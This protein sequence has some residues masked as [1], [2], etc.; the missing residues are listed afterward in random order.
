MDRHGV[1]QSS[2]PCRVL[3]VVG[4]AITGGTEAYV[5]N[6]LDHYPPD[7][8]PTVLAPFASA[9]TERWLAAGIPVHFGSVDDAALLLHS[10]ARVVELARR[11]RADVI[12]SHHSNANAV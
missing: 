7:I 2:T 11:T 1:A 12:H 5:G 4:D 3:E 10:V 8:A 6:L 9:A